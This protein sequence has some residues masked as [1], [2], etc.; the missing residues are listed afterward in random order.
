MLSIPTLALLLFPAVASAASGTFVP[1]PN[2]VTQFQ[3]RN[4]P[5]ISVSYKEV[6]LFQSSSIA[7]LL[8]SS[9]QLSAKQ[10]RE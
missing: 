3:S 9:R 6:Y 1:L 8:M 7:A 10:P 2:D 5:D 4:Y